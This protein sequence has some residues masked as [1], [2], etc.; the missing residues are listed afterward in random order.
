MN[1]NYSRWINTKIQKYKNKKKA[2]LYGSL[3]KYQRNE[4]DLI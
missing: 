3:N 1:N 2:G 4:L